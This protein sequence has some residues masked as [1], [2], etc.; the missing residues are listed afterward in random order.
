MRFININLKKLRNVNHNISKSDSL[1]VDRSFQ[2]PKFTI[3]NIIEERN[4]VYEIKIN[5]KI[6][7]LSCQ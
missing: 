6:I 5:V 1:L 7:A 2:F 3:K 4:K